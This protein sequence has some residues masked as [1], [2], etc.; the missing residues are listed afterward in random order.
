MTHFP[1]TLF[2]QYLYIE[3]RGSVSEEIEDDDDDNDTDEW[4][5][6]EAF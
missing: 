5:F 6:G 2:A 3:I 4:F 1:W